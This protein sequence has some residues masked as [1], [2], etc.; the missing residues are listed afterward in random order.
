MSLEERKPLLGNPA[1]LPQLAAA[2]APELLRLSNAAAHR[3]FSVLFSREAG[4]DDPARV[5]RI[6]V[7]SLFFETHLIKRIANAQLGRERSRALIETLRPEMYGLLYNLHPGHEDVRYEDYV[8]AYENRWRQL[9]LQFDRCERP[10][11]ARESDLMEGTLFWEF[12]KAVVA[13][14]GDPTLEKVRAV[15]EAS[16]D[17][18]EALP[19]IFEHV[20]AAQTSDPPRA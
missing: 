11:P 5:F 1:A 16:L 8:G 6:A 17:I 9:D 18:G 20:S 14:F 12:S 13:G 7:D 10:L 19:K 2:L 3:L 4:A 15:F